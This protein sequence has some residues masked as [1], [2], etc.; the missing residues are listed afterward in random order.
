L[1]EEGRSAPQSGIYGM[2]AW[3]IMTQQATDARVVALREACKE[4]LKQWVDEA[5]GTAVERLREQPDTPPSE[6]RCL[7]PKA[8]Y[9]LE[10]L[11]QYADAQPQFTALLGFL[12]DSQIQADGSWPFVTESGAGS[13]FVT[14]LVLRALASVPAARACVVRGYG[15]L[16][17]RYG[18]IANLCERLFVLNTL[19]HMRG[20][21][22]AGSDS[23]IVELP[24]EI[25]STIRALFRE[26]RSNP[27]GFANP[28]NCDFHALGKTRYFR[29]LADLVLLESCKLISGPG[30]I[31]LRAHA[32]RRLSF[33]LFASLAGG[34]FYK[35]TSGNRASTGASLYTYRLLDSIRRGRES[36]W[37]DSLLWVG[38]VLASAAAF[39]V[40]FPYNALATFVVTGL[41]A[42]SFL[43]GYDKFGWICCGAALKTAIDAFRALSET[44]AGRERA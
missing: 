36:K 8:A 32:G 27:F 33:R 10:A 13:A 15:Y 5:Q 17:S 20:M 21:G 12:M 41:G 16:Q 25:K 6:M 35:D 14:S 44:Y 30:L 18:A 28:L 24:A 37:P 34:A 7:V 9:A 1:D 39:G 42:L 19:Q 29:V 40:T 26:V 38:G 4:R 11:V 43:L 23:Q 31:Y 2:S 22:V 3:I